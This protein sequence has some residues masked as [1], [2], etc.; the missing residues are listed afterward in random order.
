M[1]QKVL[2]TGAHGR[3]GKPI[4]AALAKQG[5]T[6]RAFIR[7]ENQSSTLSKF[8]AS[9]IA[10]GDMEKPETIGPALQGCDAVV[11][12][13]PPMHPL[14]KQMTANFVSAAREAGVARFIYYSVMHPLRRDVR[15]HS[16]K[17][18]TEEMV[19]E[20]GLPYTIVQPIRYMQHLEPIWNRVCEDGVHAMPFNTHLKFNVVDLLDLADAT[21]R[22][23]LEEGWLYGTFEL[24]GPEAL[25]QDD[26]AQIIS[27]VIGKP[28]R[29]EA[30]PIAKMQEKARATGA[31]EDRVE[32]M[33]IMNEHYDRFG[34]LG[35]PRVLE[36]VLGRKPTTFRAYVERLNSN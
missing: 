31:S 14:E 7:D 15:H 5:A 34:F 19:I 17:L 9:E 32:Q 20:S 6:V 1:S 18:D 4:V 28:I 22:M 16:L 2:V 27:E 13:G 8:G 29:A 25:S 26:M 35:N 36:L 21:A 24:A 33:T 3:T 11:H 23:T 12:I 10:I 30:T